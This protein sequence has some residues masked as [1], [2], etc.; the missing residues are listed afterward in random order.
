MGNTLS[1]STTHINIVCKNAHNTLNFLYRN[2]KTC[3]PSI[4]ARLYLAYV[5][6]ILEYCCSVWDPHT[7]KDIGTLE[8][9]QKR[10]A[11]FAFN[12]YS[13]HDRVTPLLLR[14]EWIPLKERRARAKVTL[15]YKAIKNIVEISTNYLT[16]SETNDV[17]YNDDSTTDMV[18][19]QHDHFFIPYA[20][21]NPYYFSYFINTLRLWN[22]D[23]PS[24]VK[25]APSLASF[26]GALAPLTL[27]CCYEL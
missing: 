19:R 10:A 3:S 5:R 17:D 16:P 2:F 13:R 26:Q 7:D 11:R 14:L 22:F 23:L 25:D 8:A 27:R 12:T 24:N 20:R 15:L 18:T 1:W 9:V 4:K 21:T 6:P